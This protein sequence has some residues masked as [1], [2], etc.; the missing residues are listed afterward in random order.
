MGMGM[1][2]DMVMG[3]VTPIQNK[4]KNLGFKGYWGGNWSLRFK[5]LSFKEAK[6]Q[7]L[8]SVVSVVGFC[9]L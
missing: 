3:M 7:L 1:V 2:M 6:V 8:F 9:Y 5:V 4:K